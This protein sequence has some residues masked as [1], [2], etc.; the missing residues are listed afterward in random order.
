MSL[1]SSFIPPVNRVQHDGLIESFL[2]CACGRAGLRG[3]R[4]TP[5]AGLAGFAVARA[6]VMTDRCPPLTNPYAHTGTHALVRVRARAHTH[7][8]VHTHTTYIHYTRA[9]THTHTHTRAR[10]HTHAHTRMYA[11]NR[12]RLARLSC[13]S[14]NCP[15][16]PR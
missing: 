3:R 10:A 6:V 2:E 16:H 9:Q 15:F 11:R 7:T 5:Y 1:R 4:G 14:H 13:L 8:R 12:V